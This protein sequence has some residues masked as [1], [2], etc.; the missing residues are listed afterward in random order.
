MPRTD[1]FTTRWVGKRSKQLVDALLAY[2]PY[3][4]I[5]QNLEK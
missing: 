3:V 1:V 4:L 2:P 5:L